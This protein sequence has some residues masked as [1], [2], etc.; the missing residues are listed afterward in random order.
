MS[1]NPEETAEDEIRRAIGDDAYVS[2]A[3][4][5]TCKVC[6]KTDDLRFGCCFDCADHV[7]TSALHRLWDERM[8]ENV[9]YCDDDG[10]VIDP[11]K[12][13]VPV[14]QAPLGEMEDRIDQFMRGKQQDVP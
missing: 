5:G 2:M 8:P 1:K 9:W 7:K 12:W 11:A 6:G 10:N 3:R 4:P 13:N 14:P